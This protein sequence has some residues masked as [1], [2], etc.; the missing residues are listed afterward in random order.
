MTF[1]S[2]P[3]QERKETKDSLVVKDPLVSKEI[4]VFRVSVDPLDLL[5][6]QDLL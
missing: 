3:L 4:V 5:E 2:L 1:F 6:Q